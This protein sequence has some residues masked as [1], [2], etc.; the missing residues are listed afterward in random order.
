[1][2]T[3]RFGDQELRDWPRDTPKWGGE[4]KGRSAVPYYVIKGDNYDLETLS[5]NMR[6]AVFKTKKGENRFQKKQMNYRGKTM[7]EKSKPNQYA[8]YRILYQPAPIQ[9]K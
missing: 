7:S 4:E 6:H 2:W 9:N 3:A 5:I 1:M 8:Y